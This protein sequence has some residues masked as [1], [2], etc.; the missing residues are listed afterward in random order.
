MLY[1]Y[2]YTYIHTYIYIYIYIYV[3]VPTL[4]VSRV[5]RVAVRSWEGRFPDRRFDR[6]SVIFFWISSRCQSTKMPSK[7]RSGNRPSQDRTD[8]RDTRETISVYIPN[9]H[10][11]QCFHF[12]LHIS[13]SE[14]L[15]SPI[16]SS[17]PLCHFLWDHISN[18]IYR[19]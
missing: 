9:K 11:V 16:M 14:D 3:Y 5:S 7:R 4:M 19:S 12:P 6:I 8:T 13:N 10:F 1:I 17:F 18:T 15:Q 2:I